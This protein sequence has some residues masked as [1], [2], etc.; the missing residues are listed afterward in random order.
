MTNLQ[1]LS[2]SVFPVLRGPR[3]HDAGTPSFCLFWLQSPTRDL[4]RVCTDSLT[5]PEVSTELGYCNCSIQLHCLQRAPRRRVTEKAN[6]SAL[7]VGLAGPWTRAAW[8]ARSSVNPSTIHYDVGTK[9]NNAY[10][11]DLWKYESIFIWQQKTTRKSFFLWPTAKLSAE[12]LESTHVLLIC[13][14]ALILRHAW[15]SVWSR[16]QPCDIKCRAPTNQ[17]L[18]QVHPCLNAATYYV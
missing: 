8:V 14:S 12:D 18:Q 16:A 3:P 17:L 4:A 5:L 9:C 10:N 7:I 1:R 11:T 2:N 13:L 15:Y 6:F